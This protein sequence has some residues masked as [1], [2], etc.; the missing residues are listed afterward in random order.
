MG[1][2][3][4]AVRTTL[5]LALAALATLL[6]APSAGQAH[7]EREITFPDG[8]GSVPAYQIGRAHV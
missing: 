5:V 3:R 4:L 8:A 2:L 7:E 1:L 6:L